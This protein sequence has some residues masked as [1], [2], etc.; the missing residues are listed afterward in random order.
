MAYLSV[1]V[2]GLSVGYS[3]QK[4]YNL[5]GNITDTKGVVYIAKAC[6]GRYPARLVGCVHELHQLFIH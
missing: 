6:C 1:Y 5:A 4:T 2:N 3:A